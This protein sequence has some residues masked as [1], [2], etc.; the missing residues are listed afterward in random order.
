V[1]QYE[2]WVERWIDGDTVEL[3]VDVGLHLTYRDHF[4]LNGIDTPERGQP[5]YAEA[6]ARA[7]ELAPPGTRVAISTYKSDKYGRWLAD[8]HHDTETFVNQILVDEGHAKPYFG[9]TKS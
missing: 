7:N 8:V 1:Y 3:A 2:A 9:G 4:R 5:G 6:K